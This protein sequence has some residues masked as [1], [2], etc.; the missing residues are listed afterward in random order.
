MTGGRKGRRM[1]VPSCCHSFM[2]TCSQRKPE[3][4]ANRLNW[5]I[6]GTSWMLLAFQGLPP[7]TLLGRK[8]ILSAVWMSST[9]RNVRRPMC[10][11]NVPLC[12]LGRKMNVARLLIHP[13]P[14]NRLATGLVRWCFATVPPCKG[15]VQPPASWSS[16]SVNARANGPVG[17][18]MKKV[19][20]DHCTTLWGQPSKGPQ[21][22]LGCSCGEGMNQYDTG[23]QCYVS[24]IDFM[25]SS[26][27]DGG[28]NVFMWPRDF[29]RTRLL[30]TIR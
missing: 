14:A 19:N 11:D 28:A 4:V 9:A 29:D 8:P 22:F 17:C 2:N 25:N 15:T 1:W 13:F 30:A 26:R 18:G 5:M 21:I 7:R 3:V 20:L 24:D 10:R 27:P 23:R 16:R 6:L 12:L